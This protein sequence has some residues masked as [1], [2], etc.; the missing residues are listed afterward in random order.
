M[1]IALQVINLKKE[2]G[3]K[4]VLDDVSFD[5]EQGEIFG[6]IGMSGSGKTT[7]LN[8]LIGFLEPDEGEIKYHS[9]RILHQ[10]PKE[11]RELHENMMEV[12]KLFGFAP[13]AASFY[14][15]LTVQENMEHFGAL[16]KI[17]SKIIN[18][19]MERLLSMTQLD[20][21]RNKLAEHLSGGQQRRLSI[22]CGLI[23]NPEVLILDEP[24]ADLDP[25]LRDETWHLIKAINKLGTTVVV[26]SH[27]LEELEDACSR[28]IMLSNGKVA[29][30]GK[31]EDIEEKFAHDMVEIRIEAPADQLKILEQHVRRGD[32]L[33]HEDRALLLYSKTPRDTLLEIA[34]LIHSGRVKVTS[35]EVHRPR[36]KEVFEQTITHQ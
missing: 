15:R 12:K 28:V 27:L 14:P 1:V 26:A 2:Y 33:K 25:V 30:Y 24:T 34:R 19:N 8:H 36:L 23:H 31:I 3:D 22:V 18:E 35:L 17:D 6:V 29:H 21:H 9:T 32:N 13:Q 5:V 7:L 4:L 11:L 10:N 16:Q 20:V